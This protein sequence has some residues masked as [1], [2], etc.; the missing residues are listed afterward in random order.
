MWAEQT[1]VPHR[2]A[3]CSAANLIVTTQNNAGHLQMKMW[4]N[5]QYPQSS[6]ALISLAKLR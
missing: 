2:V 3:D 1:K 5:H 6:S 4:I